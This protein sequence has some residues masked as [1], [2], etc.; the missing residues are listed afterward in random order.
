[1]RRQIVT[2]PKGLVRNPF[3]QSALNCDLI[4]AGN[5]GELI[6]YTLSNDI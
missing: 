2:E 4:F 3:N 5:Q 1:M 6:S